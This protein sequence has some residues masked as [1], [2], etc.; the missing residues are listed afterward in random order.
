MAESG[1]KTY[2]K[3][4]V[5]QFINGVLKNQLS[6]LIS[7]IIQSDSFFYANFAIFEFTT[8]QCDKVKFVQLFNPL[9]SDGDNRRVS[10]L[11][12]EFDGLVQVIVFFKNPVASWRLYRDRLSH[13]ESKLGF[14]LEIEGREE[15]RLLEG[16]EEF[17]CGRSRD[18][19]RHSL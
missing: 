10:F 9:Y 16:F 14:A 8:N 5:R 11:I 2:Q 3:L 1:G 19:M 15:Y 4:K 18:L 12:S 7:P 17:N 13:I 6:P